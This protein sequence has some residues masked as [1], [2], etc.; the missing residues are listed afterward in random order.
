MATAPLL[1]VQPERH[2]PLTEVGP[3]LARLTAEV[4]YWRTSS[5]D[6]QRIADMA[7]GSRKSLELRVKYLTRKL[8]D[9]LDSDRS[10]MNCPFCEDGCGECDGFGRVPR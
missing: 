7:D 3:E 4:E 9:V 2:I 8:R 1:K 5:A 10:G 6:W